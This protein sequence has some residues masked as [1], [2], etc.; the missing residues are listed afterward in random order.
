MNEIDP[1]DAGASVWIML[2]RMEGTLNLVA[3]RVANT[4]RVVETHSED[5]GVLKS[6]TQRLSEQAV[7]RDATALAL[8]AALKEADD[9]RRTKTETAW[10][11]LTKLFS[12][13]A[14]LGV[15]WAVVSSFIPN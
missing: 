8:A 13:I 10:S 15:I 12:V 1:P 11:P 3:D 2:T 9:Q 14:A 7:A 5:I 4:I 6:T